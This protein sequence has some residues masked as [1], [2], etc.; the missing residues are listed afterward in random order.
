MYGAQKILLRGAAVTLFLFAIVA[1]AQAAT[2][3]ITPADGTYAVGDTLTV[4]VYA[5]SE[6]SMNGVSAAI[7]IPTNLFSIVSVSKAGS[8]LT[9]WAKEP[10]F[11]NTSGIVEFEGVSL[12]AGYAGTQGKILSI[13]VKA[14]QAGSAP[15]SF[16]TGSVLANDGEGTELLRGTQGSV[17]E[18]RGAKPEPETPAVSEVPPVKQATQS[19]ERG[20][21]ITSS[22]HP[23]EEKWYS[24][25]SGT[26]AWALPSNIKAV[27]TLLT[28]S[29]KATPSIIFEPPIAERVLSELE[30][31]AVYLHV[32][33]ETDSG[34]GDITHRSIRVDTVAPEA[35]SLAISQ[36][37]PRD[38][39]PEVTFATTDKG[40]G[41]DRYTI[42]V[43]GATPVALA[44]DISSYVLSALPPGDHTIVVTAVDRAGNSTS[45]SGKVMIEALDP[46]T[47]TSYPKEV[48][49]GSAMSIVGLAKEGQVVT[50]LL[51][52][53]KQSATTSA[54]VASSGM[55]E[56]KFAKA[57]ATGSYMLS[58]WVTGPDG[59]MSYPTEA[60]TIEVMGWWRIDLL[61]QVLG[62]LAVGA[63]ALVGVVLLV[64]FGMYAN[65]RLRS[66]HAHLSRRLERDMEDLEQSVH[67][68]IS[69][70]TTD[71]KVH[72]KML[73]AAKR[74]RTLSN[75]EK[76]IENN[77]RERLAAMEKD[78]AGKVHRVRIDLEK[79]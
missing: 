27:R 58:A 9:L 20:P 26:F 30:D 55:F 29:A 22:T 79:E 42:S 56:A 35:F 70:L 60:A 12:G 71:L 63:A 74:G 41:I 10:T 18:I 4:N 7:A 36:K 11:S 19:A 1:Q 45:S 64:A 66:L 73:R 69:I 33:F 31:G 51:Q 5:S 37:T 57:P 48:P 53:K 52:N 54:I 50:V 76:Y 13:V 34:W 40:S 28:K 49:S 32:Q 47:I 16:Q 44:G 15:V 68:N 65:Y 8:L 14:R 21:V 38:P 62:Y 78:L 24:A 46:P 3:Y 23:D 72:L 61:P 75:E 17:L 2:L 77:L 6:Q 25:T 59:A 67:D 39:R 43:D